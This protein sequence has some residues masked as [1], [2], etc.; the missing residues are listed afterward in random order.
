MDYASIIKAGSKA[1]RAVAKYIDKDLHTYYGLSKPAWASFKG[2][3]VGV[4]GNSLEV[5]LVVVGV[6]TIEFVSADEVRLSAVA[7][8]AFTKLWNGPNVIPDNLKDGSKEMSLWHDLVWEY[9]KMIAK[10]LGCTAQDVMCWGD[11][12]LNAAYIGYGKRRGKSVRWRARVAYNVVEW[13]RHWW[14]RFFPSAV[15]IV[16]AGALLAGCSGCATPPAW[17]LD[18]ASEIEIVATNALPR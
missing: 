15:C 18:D 17:E 16:L 3:G 12:I 2:P 11:G 4:L 9:A 10:I 8:E 7:F 1:A 5:G 14:R 6:L 13:S